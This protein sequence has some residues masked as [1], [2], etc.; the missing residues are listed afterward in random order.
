MVK[1]NNFTCNSGFTL[2]E[3][4]VSIAL[5]SLIAFSIVSITKDSTSTKMEVISEDND[6]LKVHT[7]ISAI[8]KDISQLYSPLYRQG[9]LSL[10]I[11]RPNENST[12]EER[13]S[14]SELEST[15]YNQFQHNRRFSGYAENMD[16]IPRILKESNNTITFLSN[17]YQRKNLNDNKSQFS[18]ITFTLSEPSND[19]IEELKE[20]NTGPDFKIGKNLVRFVDANDP[21]NPNLQSQDELYP[22]V[23]MDQVISVDWFFWDRKKKDFSHLEN[24]QED[25]QPITSFK[26][27]IQYYDL[28]NKEQSIEKILST[29]F[30]E[31]NI[32]AL[33]S[34][35]KNMNLP[36]QQNPYENGGEKE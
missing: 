15:L 16:L 14:F 8:E 35:Q 9:K 32:N 10:T 29:Q 21:F 12:E 23:L 20:K 30:S 13:Q 28:Y 7:A 24:L 17:G 2:I 27:K 26:I 3:V 5:L 1:R 22:Q 18:W 36:Q 19:D 33:L 6:L 4:L 34:S 31:S 25:H 11:I